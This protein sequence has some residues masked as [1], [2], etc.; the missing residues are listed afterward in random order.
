MY[1]EI[2]SANFSALCD[3]KK[4]KAT[5]KHVKTIVMCL[6][7]ETTALTSDIFVLISTGTTSATLWRLR[8]SDGWSQTTSGTFSAQV[9]T[10]CLHPPLWLMQLATLT[11]HKKTTGHAVCRKTSSRSL[12][13]WQVLSKVQMQLKVELFYSQC[14]T[15]K[16]WNIIVKLGWGN[17]N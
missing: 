4:A 15:L 3:I 6:T 11:S 12:R 8:K 2:W 5:F 13:T 14:N 1:N 9:W 10:C 17:E 7:V 16:H